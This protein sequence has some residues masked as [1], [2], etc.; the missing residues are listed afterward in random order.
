MKIRYCIH[1][2]AEERKDNFILATIHS[3]VLFSAC[4]GH[5]RSP[6]CAGV[7]DSKT[8]ADVIL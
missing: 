8:L 2:G 1:G 4:L 7:L 3:F 5:G 6:C